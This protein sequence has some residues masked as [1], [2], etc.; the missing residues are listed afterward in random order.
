MPSPTDEELIAGARAGDAGA[1]EIL[2]AR[3]QP[4]VY[5]Y[6]LRMCREPGEAED[7]QQEVLLAA[8][9]GLREF[10]GAAALD[11]WLYTI[12]R[13]QCGRRRRLR[14]GEP[15]ASRRV[16][17]ESLVEDLPDRG[18]APDQALADRQAAQAIER[19]LQALEPAQREVVLL[20]D[21]EGLTAPEVAAALG[22]TEQAVKSRLHRGRVALRAALAPLLG[23]SLPLPAV[24]PKLCP[25]ILT[26]L[27]RHLEDELTP[28][29]CAEV[30][31]HLA[32]CGWCRNESQAFER[33]LAACRSAAQQPVPAEIRQ[34]LRAALRRRAG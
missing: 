11:T 6:A 3:H 18:Q 33:S 31:R 13:R 7:V 25:S 27:S 26:Y 29:T 8:A 16:A 14:K 32:G 4:R 17:I 22:L 2:L 30:E 28:R 10:R 20:R 9:R 34:A 24:V 23:P 15:S 21:V 5:R 1:L 12:A 19:A